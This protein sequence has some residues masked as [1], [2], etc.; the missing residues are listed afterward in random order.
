MSSSRFDNVNY[1]FLSRRSMA[2][3]AVGGAFSAAVLSVGS[4]AQSTAEAKGAAKLQGADGRPLSLLDFDVDPSGRNDSSPGFRQALVEARGRKLIVP[5]GIFLVEGLGGLEA[6]GSQ[7][8]GSSRWKT[9]LRTESGAGPIFA[10]ESAARGTSAFTRIADLLLDLNGTDGVAIDLAS[11][12]ASVIQRVHVRGGEGRGQMRGIGVRFAAPLRKGA[13]DNAIYDCSFEYL[14]RAVVWAEGANSNS[15]FNCR[16]SNCRVGYDAAPSGRIDTP[17]VF[18]GRVES[19]HVGLREGATQGAYFAVRFEDNSEAD[20]EFTSS[21]LNAAVFGGHTASSASVLKNIEL[22]SSPSIESSDLGFRA[23]EESPSR[24]KV[25]TGR[26]IF[27]RAGKAPSIIAG[28]D[29]AAYFADP[30]VLGGTIRS[31]PGTTPSLGTTQ[32]PFGSVSLSDGVFVDGLRVTGRRR[33]GI[34]Q[35]NSGAQN[36]GTVNQILDVL[37]AH[38]LI[39]N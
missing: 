26:H 19:C 3:L 11:V 7:I 22:A 12:N 37:R 2:G 20:I 31:A 33:P 5:A 14:D 30:V 39:E 18:G 32:A 16:L 9:I 6:A 38:G 10:N 4:S 28:A 13:Y 23:I 1:G 24:P 8:I 17:K 36:S 29:Y 27:G 15:A 21:S 35:D 34:A 25:S